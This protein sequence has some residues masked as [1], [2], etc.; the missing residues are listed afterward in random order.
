MR[1]QLQIEIFRN[2][3]YLQHLFST[4]DLESFLHTAIDQ[5][6]IFQFSAGKRIRN[7]LLLPQSTLVKLFQQEGITRSEDM[8]AALLAVFHEYLCITGLRAN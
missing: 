1:Q 4:E 3:P 6:F 8:S 5:L 7:E 2:F